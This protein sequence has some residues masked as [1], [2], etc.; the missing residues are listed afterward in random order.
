VISF[1]AIGLR[2][3]G[4]PRSLFAEIEKDSATPGA[5]SALPFA[6]ITDDEIDS[7]FSHA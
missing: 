1:H 2:S 7:L 4:L 3:L 5:K 6:E